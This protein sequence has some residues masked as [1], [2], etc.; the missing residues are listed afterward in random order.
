MINKCLF[1]GKEFERI[2]YITYKSF[3]SIYC[4]IQYYKIKYEITNCYYCNELF[5]PK[6]EHQIFCHY[7]CYKKEYFKQKRFIKFKRREKLKNII[8]LFTNQEYQKKKNATK[9]ICKGF[10]CEPHYVGI[11]NL[12]DDHIYPVSIAYID[13]LKTGIKRIYTINDIQFLCFSCNLSKFNKIIEVSI[14]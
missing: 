3:D 12:T 5:I 2:K 6:N 9:G 14:S 13:F 1:C 10:N 4:L 7:N 11:E 8:H